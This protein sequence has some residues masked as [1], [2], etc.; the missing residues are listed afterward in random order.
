MMCHAIAT[1]CHLSHDGLSLS[2]RSGVGS[3]YGTFSKP[4][5]SLSPLAKL[6]P[7]YVSEKKNLSTSPAKKGTGYG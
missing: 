1:Q 7:P 4:T 5:A 6:Q 3:L 2:F